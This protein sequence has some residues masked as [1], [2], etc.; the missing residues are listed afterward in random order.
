MKV[1]ARNPIV[2]PNPIPIFAERFRVFE[3]DGIPSEG[4]DDAVRV[5][6][7]EM[8]VAVGMAAETS[9][10]GAFVIVVRLLD[11]ELTPLLSISD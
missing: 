8:E 6:V 11:V 10:D 5:S 7:V 9:E 2:A 4:S 1:N 3:F